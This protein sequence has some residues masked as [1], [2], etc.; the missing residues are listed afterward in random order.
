MDIPC[1]N[2]R[3]EQQGEAQDRE[4]DLPPLFSRTN[5]CVYLV[6][7]LGIEHLQGSMVCVCKDCNGFVVRTA[8]KHEHTR[9]LFFFKEHPASRA[10]ICIGSYRTAPRRPRQHPTPHPPIPQPVCMKAAATAATAAPKLGDGPGLE[11]LLN[12]SDALWGGGVGTGAGGDKSAGGG[13]VEKTAEWLALG[14]RAVAIESC[15]FVVQVLKAAR[16][17]TIGGWVVG[18]LSGTDCGSFGVDVQNMRCGLG[19]I[20]CFFGGH[21][22]VL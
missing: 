22:N 3:W 13:E 20:S 12:A 2:K 7:V 6:M 15:L 9:V 19:M 5:V 18:L 21:R 11:G 4:R 10:C 17:R 8:V 16:R 1:I 14:E